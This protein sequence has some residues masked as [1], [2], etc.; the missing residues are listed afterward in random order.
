MNCW[1]EDDSWSPKNP[2]LRDNEQ[3][4]SE[5]GSPESKQTKT[6][7]TG[8]SE[9]DQESAE[10]TEREFCKSW[11]SYGRSNEATAV[12]PTESEVECPWEGP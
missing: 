11:W 6:D 8:W 2:E 3:E 4:A 1:S 7:G 5:G 12:G 10:G 9:E